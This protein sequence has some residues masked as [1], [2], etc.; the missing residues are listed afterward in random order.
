MKYI[1]MLNIDTNNL[2]SLE[3]INNELTDKVLIQL[4]VDGLVD[5]IEH[6]GELEVYNPVNINPLLTQLDELY[7]KQCIDL[8]FGQ[9]EFLEKDI[10][11]SISVLIKLLE[12]VGINIKI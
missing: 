12:F 7:L 4:N 11:E 2:F 8:Y 9:R 6:I 1:E 5:S 3:D 10:E